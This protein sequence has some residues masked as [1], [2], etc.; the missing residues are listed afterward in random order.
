[1]CKRRPQGRDLFRHPYGRFY[2][3]PR[4][5]AQHGHQ[6]TLLLLD[7]ARGAETTRNEGLL[8]IKSVPLRYLTPGKYISEARS[9]CLSLNPDWILAFSDTWYGLLADHLGRR[10]QRKVLIDAY[11]NY[12]AYIP[13]AFPL[14]WAWRR[15]CRNATAVTAA[16]P[17]LLSIMTKERTD[18]NATII[19]MAADPCFMPLDRDRCR[20]ALGLPPSTPLIGY[21]GSLNDNRDVSTLFELIRLLPRLEPE[22]RFV[23]SGRSFVTI[24]G[25]LF[26]K[27]IQMGYLPADQVPLV[28]NAI[29]V[30]VSLNNPNI[31]GTYSYPVKLYEA[32]QCTVPVVTTDVGGCRWILRDHPV[33]VVPYGDLNALL[34]RICTALTWKRMYYKNRPNWSDNATLFEQVLTRHTSSVD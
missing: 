9:I 34:N 11:D 21:L 12:E 29:D 26:D 4:L 16:G 24:P 31:F 22:A 20:A 23:L 13:W 25:D 8:R 17:D 33:C 15:A 10:F 2:H 28:F 3:I 30:L 32:M 7:Y 18:T 5:L 19:P 27:V 6:V 14:H 1:M